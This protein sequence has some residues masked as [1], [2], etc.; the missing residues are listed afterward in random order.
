M[1]RKKNANYGNN[2]LLGTYGILKDNNNIN[3]TFQ[4]CDK[5]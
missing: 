3:D 4:S 5:R 2:F 1:H